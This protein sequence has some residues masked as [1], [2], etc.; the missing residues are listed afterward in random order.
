MILELNAKPARN[1]R[2]KIG[3]DINLQRAI[4]LDA[5]MLKRHGHGHPCLDEGQ[6][7][8]VGKPSAGCHY[9]DIGQDWTQIVGWAKESKESVIQG[10]G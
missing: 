3:Y 7:S 6:G 9:G 1:K 2:L 8:G 4:E 5:K 10:Q